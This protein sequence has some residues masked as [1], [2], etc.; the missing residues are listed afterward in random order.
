M[1]LKLDWNSRSV[2]EGRQTYPSV[3]K[4]PVEAGPDVGSRKQGLNKSLLEYMRELFNDQ[5]K[6]SWSVDATMRQVYRD[7]TFFVGG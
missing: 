5:L 7:T 6:K 1:N 3:I 2:T 4:S